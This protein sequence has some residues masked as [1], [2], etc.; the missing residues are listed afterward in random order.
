[1]RRADD[2]QKP[3][4]IGFELKNEGDCV[5][6]IDELEPL[7]TRGRGYE[8]AQHALGICLMRLGGLP[9][10][11]GEPPVRHTLTGNAE[12]REGLAWVSRSA[13]AGSFQAQRTMVALYAADLAP[14]TDPTE[15]AKWLHLY[16]V[17]PVRLAL[18]VAPGEDEAL[19]DFESSL[20]A[21]TLIAGKM[22]A[23]QWTPTFWSPQ[24]DT[25][26]RIV[27]NDEQN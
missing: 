22:R 1:M 12:F 17:N 21:G 14:D 18:G 8:E 24:A 25:A 16:K 11:A 9:A 6:A 3:Y 23:R 27:A 10:G 5:A 26:H 2:P 4:W 19:R 13:Q 15:A 20:P 7:A